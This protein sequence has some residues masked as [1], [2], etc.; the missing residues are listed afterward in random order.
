MPL[1]QE[2]H[3]L[4]QLGTLYYRRNDYLR[5]TDGSNRVIGTYCGQ[6]TGRSVLVNDTVAVLYFRA[7]GSVQFN[8]FQLLFSFF[9]RGK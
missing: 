8:G 2:Y 6:Q 4:L 5:I 7:D 9:P 1:I 3:N